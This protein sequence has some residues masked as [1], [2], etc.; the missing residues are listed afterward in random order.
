MFQ[1]VEHAPTSNQSIDLN[2]KFKGFNRRQTHEKVFQGQGCLNQKQKHFA[3]N[4]VASNNLLDSHKC[5]STNIN[6]SL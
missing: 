2:S 3:W 4:E 6:S 1:T 5:P